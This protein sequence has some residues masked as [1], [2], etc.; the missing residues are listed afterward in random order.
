[1]AE[2]QGTKQSSLTGLPQSGNTGCDADPPFMVPPLRLAGESKKH[3]GNSTVTRFS[4]K[5]C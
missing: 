3:V 5:D 4:Q 1:M 2:H